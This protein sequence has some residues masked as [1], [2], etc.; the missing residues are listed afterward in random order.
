MKLLDEMIQKAEATDDILVYK[1]HPVIY[2]EIKAHL[3]SANPENDSIRK[4][5]GLEIYPDESVPRR[6]YLRHRR[7]P[8]GKL[9]HKKELYSW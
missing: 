6:K 8:G 2:K 4:D 7:E 3:R 5:I 9:Q 1:I